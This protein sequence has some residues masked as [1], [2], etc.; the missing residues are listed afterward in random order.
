MPLHLPAIIAAR[1]HSSLPPTDALGPG[2]A[3]HPPL[4]REEQHRGPV[5]TSTSS[6]VLEAS[7]PRTFCR[8]PTPPRRAWSRA[9][10][11]SSW[12]PAHLPATYLRL[13]PTAIQIPTLPALDQPLSPLRQHPARFC[14]AAAFVPELRAMRLT[15]LALCLAASA[16]GAAQAI[17]AES[18][19]DPARE[20]AYFNGKKV[21]PLLELTAENFDQEVRLSKFL[22][23]K[24]FRCA[25]YPLPFP[26]A[27][28]SSPHCRVVT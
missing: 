26:A 2:V 12:R 11:F 24:F 13:S 16:W 5:L 3:I 20:S 6:C 18:Q 17:G 10:L 9:S 8:Q 14:C 7:R 22:V 1:L 28:T 25:S 19:N 21:P 15:S 23:V 4:N 27:A